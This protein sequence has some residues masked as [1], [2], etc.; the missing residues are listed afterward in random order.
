M[1]AVTEQTP[2]ARGT[3]V[4]AEDDE[5]TRTLLCVVLRRAGFSVNAFENGQLAYDA[6]RKQQ[7][8]VVLLDWMMPVLDGH[9]VV[10]L[11]K[12][13]IELRGI[14]IVMLTTHSQIEECV[15]ALETGVQDFLSKP[16]DPRELIARIDQ[17]MRWRRLMAA[18]ANTAFAAQRLQLY[19]ESPA[20]SIRTTAEPNFFDRIWGDGKAAKGQ[21]SR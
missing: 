5:T 3:I 9:A 1:T 12:A 18:D 21:P 8:D 4:V 2:P 6:I 11:L 20:S 17:Q 19:R 13:D 10:V 14:P 16:F 15:A 7:P